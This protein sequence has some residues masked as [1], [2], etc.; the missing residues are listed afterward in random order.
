MVF[1]ILQIL[2]L[3]FASFLEQE[4]IFPKMLGGECLPGAKQKERCFF[5]LVAVNLFDLS[6]TSYWNFSSVGQAVSVISL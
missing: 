4:L 2:L 6:L 5:F 3:V 1:L